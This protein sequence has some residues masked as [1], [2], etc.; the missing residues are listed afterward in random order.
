MGALELPLSHVGRLDL[1]ELGFHGLG[2]ERPRFASMTL[3]YD[4]QYVCKYDMWRGSQIL[5]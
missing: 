4:G 1:H 3:Y 2:R 5:S